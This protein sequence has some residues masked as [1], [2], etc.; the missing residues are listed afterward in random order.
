MTQS[1]DSSISFSPPSIQHQVALVG[2]PDMLRLSP[3]MAAVLSPSFW[4]F[5]P[6]FFSSSAFCESD[7]PQLFIS[8]HSAKKKDA[9][10]N[11]YI[12]H[13][14]DQLLSEHYF[15]GDFLQLSFGNGMG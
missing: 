13:F 2:L 11:P 3:G 7:I 5:S 6:L 9:M 4:I 8:V 1:R 15:L 14:L 12:T 10:C